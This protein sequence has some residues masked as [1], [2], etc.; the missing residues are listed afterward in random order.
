MTMDTLVN[1][2][3]IRNA[4]GWCGIMNLIIL[5]IW[6]LMILMADEFIY[7]IH[8]RFFKVTRK[9]FDAIHYQGMMFFKVFVL[10]FNIVPYMALRIV[11]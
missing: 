1:L 9:R 5:V 6:F 7:R 8:S 2:E 4:F 10:M 3:L 11:G